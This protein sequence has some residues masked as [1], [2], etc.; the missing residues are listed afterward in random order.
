MCHLCCTNITFI[1]SHEPCYSY[2]YNVRKTVCPNSV[3]EWTKKI[4]RLEKVI[5]QYLAIV[6]EWDYLYHRG[7][8][9][10]PKLYL[11][12]KVFV[13]PFPIFPSLKRPCSFSVKTWYPAVM[14]MLTIS[15]KSLVPNTMKVWFYRRLEFVSDKDN[16]IVLGFV[17]EHTIYWILVTFV[18]TLVTFNTPS[19]QCWFTFF[20][21]RSL[22]E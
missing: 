17:A 8:I 13:W 4:W 21:I 7:C 9:F 10:S 5:Q 18:E 11:L 22:S 19:S 15:S 16:W 12:R 14:K 20:P 2:K 6:I 3:K 1:T